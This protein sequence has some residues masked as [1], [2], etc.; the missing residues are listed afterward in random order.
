MST[1]KC[2]L[3]ELPAEDKSLN[4]G[5]SFK[6]RYDSEPKSRKLE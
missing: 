5:G 1:A 3:E 6:F 2:Y 4:R